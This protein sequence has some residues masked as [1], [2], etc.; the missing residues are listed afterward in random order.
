MMRPAYPWTFTRTIRFLIGGLALIC[1]AAAAESPTLSI[2]LG[3]S[4]LPS[5]FWPALITN[6]AYAVQTTDALGTGVWSFAEPIDQWPSAET[7]WLSAADAGEA[8]F[9]RLQAVHRG[10][11]VSNAHEVT[12]STFDIT[13]LFLALG[14]DHLIAAS[15]AVSIYDIVYETFDH[16]NLST[17]AAG[18]LLVPEGVSNAPLISLQHGTTSKDAE[19]PSA[20]TEQAALGVVFATHGYAAV[21]PDYL[22]LGGY[23]PGLHPYLH[24]KSEAVAAV[25]ML[26]ACRTFIQTY[27]A[28]TLNGQLFLAGYSQG[29]QVTMALQRELERYHTNEFQ[30]TASAP[31]AGPYA[32]SGVMSEVIETTNSYSSPSYLA[33]LLLGYDSVYGLFDSYDEVFADPYHTSIPPLFDGSKTTGEIDDQLPD[34]PQDMLQPAYL[35]AV[36]NN[37]DHPLRV[38]LRA[39]DTYDWTPVAPVRLYHCSGDTTVPFTNSQIAEAQFKTNG[40]P[41]VA[42]IDPA[43]GAD[44]GACVY[45]SILAA[46]AWFDSLR[47]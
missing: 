39:N 8:V 13:L 4:N 11:L 12:L 44:H 6:D 20:A 40:A 34:V 37:P 7:N 19:A 46:K 14:I 30:I 10:N 15:N 29:G 25:D 16:R 45:P 1:L 5:L 33:Y 41:D 22:G 24:A 36:T 3:P 38:A 2:G 35:Q 28:L 17:I 47:E 32:L 21:I 43:P 23:S 18:A 31:M 9:Y 42:L 26:R 27:T